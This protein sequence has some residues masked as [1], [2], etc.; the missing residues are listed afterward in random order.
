MPAALGAHPILIRRPR[1]AGCRV[2]HLHLRSAPLTRDRREILTHAAILARRCILNWPQPDMT[3]P[4]PMLLPVTGVIL[5]AGASSRMG[6]T[7]ALLPIGGDTF[8]SR[9]TRTMA[10]GGVGTVIVVVADAA[11]GIRQAVAEDRVNT[12]V[13]VVENPRWQE[14][15]LSSFIAGLDGIGHNPVAGAL[16]TPVDMPL[17]SPD[18]VARLIAA[19]R[20]TGAPVVRPVSGARHGHPVLFSASMFDEIR[21]ADPAMG[22]RAVVRAHAAEIAD[23]E[24]DDAGAFVDIDTPEDY[25]LWITGKELDACRRP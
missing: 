23:I 21:L 16:I 20:A 10:A 15:Q 18:T 4:L 19:F 2:L 17:F 3:T 22:A 12:P 7:K 5:A 14:G 6:R 9:I 8:V 11:A 1:G 13:I 25:R 24:I